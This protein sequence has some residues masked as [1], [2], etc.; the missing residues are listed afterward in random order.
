MRI[1]KHLLCSAWLW[2]T[3]AL[4]DYVKA[5]VSFSGISEESKLVYMS[6][7]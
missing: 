4:Y 2:D 7:R 1:Y 5:L 3:E 6:D